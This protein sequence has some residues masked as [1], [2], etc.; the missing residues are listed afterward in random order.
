MDIFSSIEINSSGMSAERKR[1]NLISSNIA[2]ARTTRTKE[3]GPYKRKDAV[4][5]AT[6]LD[7]VSKEDGSQAPGVLVSKIL[8]DSAPPQLKYEPNNPDADANGYVA[9]PNIS[10]VEEMVNMI[11]AT[12]SYEANAASVQAAKDMA[13]KALNISS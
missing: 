6:P 2:N 7:G 3:G 1:M 10:V 4:F 12:K 8:E 11:T 5:Q 9:Y 13:K